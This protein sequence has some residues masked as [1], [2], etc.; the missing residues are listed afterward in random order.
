M[1]RIRN[2]L[3][4]LLSGL[5]G[6]QQYGS[7]AKLEPYQDKQGNENGLERSPTS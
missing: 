4:L 7:V 3:D 6:E 5:L 2:V 1:G